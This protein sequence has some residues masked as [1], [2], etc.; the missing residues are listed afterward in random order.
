MKTVGQ[1]GDTL[2][3]AS[4]L[5]SAKDEKFIHPKELPVRMDETPTNDLSSSKD[6]P[7]S[8]SSKIEITAAR[9]QNASPS[10]NINFLSS[11]STKQN[12]SK[13]PQ[14]INVGMRGTKKSGNGGLLG[15][16][17]DSFL[18]SL[19]ALSVPLLGAGGL[20]LAVVYFY[21]PST[22][23]FFVSWVLGFVGMA[24]F[25]FGAILASAFLTYKPFG[26]KPS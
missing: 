12:S 10:Q 23:G 11:E 13:L 21:G 17:I 7:I 24:L 22:F 15:A 9:G 3:S 20:I 6:A 26:A 19:T 1:A 14:K 4:I 18:I 2:I 5:S 25:V 8:V 16:F